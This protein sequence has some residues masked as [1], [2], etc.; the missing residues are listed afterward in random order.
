MKDKDLEENM[1]GAKELAF[2]Y[3][4]RE[5]H[6]CKEIITNKALVLSCLQEYDS[7]HDVR[8]RY[9]NPKLGKKLL[10]Q[11]LPR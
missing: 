6:S 7:V 2:P 5:K 4:E 8:E 11:M 3:T 9:K 1:F 10:A